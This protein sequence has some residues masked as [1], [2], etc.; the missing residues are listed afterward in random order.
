MSTLTNYILNHTSDLVMNTFFSFFGFFI[1]ILL[2][3]KNNNPINTNG[4]SI[5]NTIQFIQHNVV[6]HHQ[7]TI[8]TSRKRPIHKEDDDESIVGVW[9]FGLVVS[10]FLFVKYHQ[11]IINFFTGFI[12]FALVSTITIAIKLYR[13]NQY[14]NLNRFWTAVALVIITVDFITLR[15]M[16]NQINASIQSDTLTNF[17]NSAGMHGIMD[18]AY[19]AAGFAFVMIPNL[20]LLV[21]LIHMYA[22]NIYLASGNRIAGFIIRKTNPFTIKPVAIASIGIILCAMSLLF[23]SGTMYQLVSKSTLSVHPTA[24]T[25]TVGSHQ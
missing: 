4:S 12:C 16:G 14:D 18:Y 11:A 25:Q 24:T 10:A 8:N 6:T 22:V 23:S 2:T 20:L 13:N 19:S 7:Q 3:P 1:S 17:I 21:L 5:Y 9:I 15:F